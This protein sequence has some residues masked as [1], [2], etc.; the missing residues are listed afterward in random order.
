MI[1]TAESPVG[2]NLLHLFCEF[3]RTGDFADIGLCV[4]ENNGLKRRDR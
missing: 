4:V 2:L 3:F 1:R